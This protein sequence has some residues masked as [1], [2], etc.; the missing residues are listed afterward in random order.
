MCLRQIFQAHDEIGMETVLV[1]GANGSDRIAFAIGVAM[2]PDD[3]IRVIECSGELQLLLVQ[4][5]GSVIG[6]LPP[7]LVAETVGTLLD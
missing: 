6:G 7:L 4:R 5:Q 1:I 3:E 2:P